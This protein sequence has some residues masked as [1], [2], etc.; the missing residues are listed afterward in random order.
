MQRHLGVQLL[1]I[2]VLAA[3]AFWV[4][5]PSTTMIRIVNPLNGQSLI[6][7]DAS[8]RRGLDLQGGLQVVLEADVP[9]G[10]E[11]D[12]ERMQAVRDIIER[13]V[14]A[15]G[16]TEPV[17]Q[18]AGNNRVIV[19]LP[20]IED[21]NRA[22]ATFGETGLLEFID[23][24]FPSEAPQVGE[25]V[26]TDFGTQA[27]VT[28]TANV[29]V[30]RTIFTGA[31]LRSAEIAFD[32]NT[33]QPQIAFEFKS[34]EPTRRLAEFTRNNVG[35]IMAITLD[36][37]VISTPVIRDEI[38]DGRGVI[39][40]DFTLEEAQ[41]LVIQLRYGALPV[42]LKI[43]QV[44]AVG[45]TLGEDS[46]QRSVRAG[47]IGVL[48]V[49]AFML[50]YYRLPGLLANVALVIYGAI[51]LAL[52]KLIPVTLTLA[53]IA[54]FVL[55]V[56]MAVDA[57]ILIF[58][59]MKEELRAGRSLV[60][61]VHIGFRRA[62]PSIRDSNVSTLITCAILFWFGATF[63][64]SIVKGFAVTLALGVMVSLFTAVTVTR[65]FLHVVMSSGLVRNRWWFG[66]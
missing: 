5:L 41:A 27:P 8:Y 17:I 40:G 57:N 65:T 24:G 38:P 58:E 3:I 31:D 43:V 64:A 53:G 59:R 63:G 39:E 66:V 11:V 55:S 34:G 35:R 25:R 13:R 61:A 36:K 19:E 44:R 1:A 60:A 6:E 18:L 42:P 33:N 29:R 50:L 48:S 32:P 16:T 45:A 10:T 51:A 52:F 47:V 2:T 37:V 12:S 46:I 26:V 15:L 9:P 20:G 54:G 21:P 22:I 7:R 28:D 56:G 49:V 62:W 14:N 4:A 23:A 30:Y